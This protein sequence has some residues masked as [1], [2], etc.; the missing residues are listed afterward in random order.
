MFQY[1]VSYGV[2]VRRAFSNYATFYGRAS[3]SEYW[4]FYLFFIVVFYALYG[5]GMILMVTGEYNYSALGIIGIIIMI[6]ACF[7]GLACAL[8]SWAVTIRRL[9]DTGRSGWN[10]CWGLIPFVG[11]IIVIIL[12]AQPSQMQVNQ[13]GPIPNIRA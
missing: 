13:Y 5:A 2:A 3:R 8:P 9:H 7:A 11:M 12:L 1:R 6:L 10:C 4:W